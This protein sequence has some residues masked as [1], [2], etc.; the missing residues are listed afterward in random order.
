MMVAGAFM[1]ALQLSKK[2]T[3]LI[4]KVAQITKWVSRTKYTQNE[5]SP[6]LIAVS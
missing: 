2:E 5:A 6:L 1:P 3:H 4:Q